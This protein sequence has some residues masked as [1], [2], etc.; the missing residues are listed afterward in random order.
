[1]KEF[2]SKTI[3]DTEDEKVVKRIYDILT[4]SG[5]DT[6]VIDKFLTDRAIDDAKKMILS[7]FES[8]SN[9]A[10]FFK[11]CNGEISLPNAAALVAGTNIYDVFGNLGFN[12]DTLVD[13][14][15]TNPPRNSITRGWYEILS[16]IFLND[17][18]P[19]N[20]GRGDV[21]AGTQ[22]QM[23]YKAPNARI[24][25]QNIEPTEK[26]DKKFEELCKGVIDLESARLGGSYLFAI[27][28]IKKQL[29]VLFKDTPQDTVVDIIARSL[30]A[31]FD[32][33]N[34]EWI[35]FVKN[36]KNELFKGKVIDTEFI[37]VLFGVMDLYFYQHD[38]QFTHMILFKGKQKNDKGDYVVL[39]ADMFKTFESI[40]TAVKNNG[41]SFTAM[42][43]VSSV[44]KNSREWVVQIAAI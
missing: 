39:T 14:A 25:G 10:E 44:S 32:E 31:Q 26:I 34:A 27:H 22:Y 28:T 30:I 33:D 5:L 11:L 20:K 38:E 43:R 17:I 24:K 9:L 1:M 18:T 13:L 2:I 4:K 16:Q 29:S 21:N 36:H 19:G 40:Y 12:K 42:P 15:T 23:E 7:V 3:V 35:A 6:M 37:K 8:N 41:I